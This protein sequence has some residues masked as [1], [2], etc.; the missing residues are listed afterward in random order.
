VENLSTLCEVIIQPLL[1]SNYISHD[2]AHSIFSNLDYK[3]IKI[4]VILLQELEKRIQAWHNYQPLGDIFC[5]FADEFKSYHHYI[6]NYN[7]S[8][9]LLTK[10]RQSNPPFDNFLKEARNGTRCKNLGASDF[11]IM[12]IQ[13][14]PRYELLLSDLLRNTEVDTL[15]HKNIKDALSQV[16]DT[17]N[18]INDLKRQQDSVIRMK[19]VESKVIGTS[20]PTSLVKDGRVLL[21]EGKLS[22]INSSTGKETQVY[23]FLFNDTLMSTKMAAIRK[24]LIDRTM[25]YDHQKDIPLETCT[26]EDIVPNAD[27][28]GIIN[29]LCFKLNIKS[30]PGRPATICLLKAANWYEKLAWLSDLRNAI[31]NCKKVIE[32]FYKTEFEVF[33]PK[34]YAKAYKM[35]N[36]TEVGEGKLYLMDTGACRTIITLKEKNKFKIK[37]KYQVLMLD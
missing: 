25:R 9:E 16:K 12:P 32:G 23:V 28:K 2:L 3:I 29:E 20:K 26:L 34:C 13:R 8:L 36:D 1:K 37:K 17:V 35:D 30:A 15:D 4:H 11:L 31:E 21:R 24:N 7:D 14:L 22:Q 5:H 18:Y 10:E 27:E 33:V 19:I 6:T